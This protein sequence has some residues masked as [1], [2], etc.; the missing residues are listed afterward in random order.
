MMMVVLALQSKIISRQARPVEG[1]NW[2]VQHTLSEDVPFI[3]W[4]NHCF[5]MLM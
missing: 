3:G 4:I 5:Y 1:C 2:L